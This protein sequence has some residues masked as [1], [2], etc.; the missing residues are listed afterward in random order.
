MTLSAITLISES[1]PEPPT[2]DVAISHALLNAVAAGTISQ[3][4]RLHGARPLLAFGMVDRTQAGYPQAVKVAK[5]HGF[6]PIERLAGGRAAVFHETTLAFSWAT[7]ETDSRDGITRRFEFISTILTK[8]F[9]SLGIDARVGEIPGEYCPGRYSVNVGGAVKVMGVGQRLIRGAAH[10]GGVIV[11][12][13]SDR[14]RDV[15]IPVYR[16]LNLDWDPRT[17]GALADRSPG[18]STKDVTDSIVF[19]LSQVFNVE[20]GNVPDSVIAVAH[21]LNDSHIPKVA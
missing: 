13:D 20:P 4:F 11:I 2:Q 12:N 15:L 19:E 3:L 1:F 21:T 16:A 14:I 18:L 10:V 8:A 5:A 17:V 7:P 9:R 6:E